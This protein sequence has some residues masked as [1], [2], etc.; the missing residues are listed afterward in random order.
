ML[1][2]PPPSDPSDIKSAELYNLAR[3]GSEA[4]K[5]EYLN[6][7]NKKGS[8]AKICSFFRLRYTNIVSYH[9]RSSIMISFKGR[10]FPKDLILICTRWY[11]AYPLSY[12]NIEEMMLERGVEVD[13]STINRWV[14]KYSQELEK[15]F[16]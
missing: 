11:V 15:K 10:H 5:L 13:N 12:R 4:A 8:V 16:N 1:K 6:R 2:I 3:R 7:E 14:V 9:G